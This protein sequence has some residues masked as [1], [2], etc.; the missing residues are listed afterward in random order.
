M[1]NC[2]GTG[3]TAVEGRGDLCVPTTKGDILMRGILDV[4]YASYLGL[5][6][7]RLGILSVIEG[8]PERAKKLIR[9][10]YTESNLSYRSIWRPMR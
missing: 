8:Q 3:E 2:G 9:W 7:D 5:S 4:V 1:R 10:V 6:F